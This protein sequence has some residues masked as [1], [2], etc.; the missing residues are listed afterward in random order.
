MLLQG[1]LDRRWVAGTQFR[2][3]IV[4]CP[5]AV[6]ASIVRTYAADQQRWLADFTAVFNKLIDMSFTI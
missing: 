1:L 6:T 2:S 3:G 4:E 5:E